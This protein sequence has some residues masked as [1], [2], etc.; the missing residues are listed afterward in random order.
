MASSHNEL[1]LFLWLYVDAYMSVFA[2]SL[3]EALLYMGGMFVGLA[4]WHSGGNP[5]MHFYGYDFA[6]FPCHKMVN[7]A[8]SLFIVGNVNNFALHFIGETA[9]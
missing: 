6:N 9:L 1:S 7:V 8:H 3:P 4:N 2:E 5:Y